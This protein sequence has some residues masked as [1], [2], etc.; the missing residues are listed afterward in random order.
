MDEQIDMGQT[1]KKK[2]IQSRFTRGMFIMGIL[3]VLI[4]SV[5]VGVLL[6]RDKMNSYSRM[7]Y[8][9][10]RSIAEYIDG[11]TIA[12]YMDT[13]VKDSYYMEVDKFLDAVQTK[14]DIEYFYIIIPDGENYIYVWDSVNEHL[15]S[16]IGYVEHFSKKEAEHVQKIMN[17]TYSEKLYIT[18]DSMY[19]HLGTA[20]SPIYDSNDEIV[21]IVA[22]D[23]DMS[24]VSVI[25]ALFILFVAICIAI[26]L[27][28]TIVIYYFV[29]KSTIIVPISKL[30]RIT[31]TMVKNIDSN[32]EIELDIHTGDEIEELAESYKKMYYEMREYIDEN[33]KITAERE[34]VDSELQIARTIQNGMLPKLF[35][36][37]VDSDYYDMFAS[38]DPAREVGG[39]FYDFFMVD[40]NH[41]ALLIADV[42]D[43]GIGAALFMSISKALIKMRMEMTKSPLETITY[44]DKKISENNE[45]GMFVT[46]W[47]GV[48]NLE[49]G[50]VVACNAGHDYPA[51]MHQGEDFKVE[52][53]PHGPAVAFLPGMTFND[54]EFD[55][56]VGDRIFL[57]TDGLVEAKD[58][59]GKRF[60]IEKM[61]DILNNNKDEKNED[62]LNIMKKE[63]ETFSKGE[64]Q[65]DDMT[66]LGFTFYGKKVN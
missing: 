39:D 50:H 51:I 19:G 64:N 45:I 48:V 63:V 27:T 17:G 23:V 12:T 4:T 42:S 18:N 8:G 11:D 46:V 14:S 29:T 32:E 43:K 41:L 57:Y 33:T 21:A 55:L 31:S 54:I 15:K 13:K 36:D 5:N 24:M 25:V 40:E 52:K 7:A 28:I 59:G 10:T 9:Y 26:V 61:L 53:T 35:P 44:V 16:N 6:Y 65:F 1:K 20:Y 47:L 60:G 62:L 38:M 49:T 2:S 58:T 30:N 34:K 37:Y 22:A 56:K 3:T 66:M